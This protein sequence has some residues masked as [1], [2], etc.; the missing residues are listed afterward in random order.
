MIFFPKIS[1]SAM[2]VALQLSEI[3]NFLITFALLG[4]FLADPGPPEANTTVRSFQIVFSMVVSMPPQCL[5]GGPFRRGGAHGGQ[6]PH[7]PLPSALVFKSLFWT[8]DTPHVNEGTARGD[9]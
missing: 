2:N 8:C 3:A 1:T 5:G 9:G 7:V 4:S 6:T